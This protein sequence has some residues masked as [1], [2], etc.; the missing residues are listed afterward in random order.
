MKRCGLELPRVREI[1]NTKR[2]IDWDKAEWPIDIT[3]LAITLAGISKDKTLRDKILNKKS[4][5]ITPIDEHGSTA[6]GEPGNNVEPINEEPEIDDVDAEK[7]TPRIPGISDN[8][9]P[10][11]EDNDEDLPDK[12]TP[13][14]PETGEDKAVQPS[15]KEPTE[16]KPSSAVDP[17]EAMK[18]DGWDGE[19]Y[20]IHISYKTQNYLE[21]IQQWKLVLSF[22][23]KLRTENR[24]YQKKG[25]IQSLRS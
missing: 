25:V 8:D 19:P 21:R 23:I 5:R 6:S 4:S 9:W 18:L 17:I 24:I 20:K 22:G 3:A 12:S 1:P 11:K 16:D 14:I 2:E 13:R 10:E 7:L 15:S